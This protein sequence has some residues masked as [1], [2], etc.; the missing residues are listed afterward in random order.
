MLFFLATYKEKVISGVRMLWFFKM[1]C[2]SVCFDILWQIANV[3]VLNCS[4]LLIQEVKLLKTAWLF[5]TVILWTMPK[6]KP[7]L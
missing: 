1:Y 2:Y 4:W 6:D 5:L 7:S 3:D